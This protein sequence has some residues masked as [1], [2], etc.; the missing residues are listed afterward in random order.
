MFFFEKSLVLTKA[1]LSDQKVNIYIH[2]ILPK[3]FSHPL[4]MKG[5]TTLVISMSTNLNV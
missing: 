5:L 2:I 1:A 3:V 4:L